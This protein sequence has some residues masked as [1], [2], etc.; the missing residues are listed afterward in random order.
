LDD[1]PA[2]PS[3]ARIKPGNSSPEKPSVKTPGH[4]QNARDG[5]A[6]FGLPTG[7]G[8]NRVRTK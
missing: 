7:I 5:G 1:K 6:D 3:A 4:F 2:Q 8:G